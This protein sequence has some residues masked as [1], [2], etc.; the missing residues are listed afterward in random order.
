MKDTLKVDRG[1]F[2]KVYFEKTYMEE[3]LKMKNMM[4]KKKWMLFIVIIYII[5]SQYY[6]LSQSDLLFLEITTPL[7]PINLGILNL[8]SSVSN[9]SCYSIMIICAFSILLVSLC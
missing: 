3:L 2:R 5:L 6:L 9:L 4:H 7:S 8:S 1:H